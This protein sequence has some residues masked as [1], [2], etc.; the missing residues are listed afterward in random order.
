MNDPHS[1]SDGPFSKGVG[2][3]YKNIEPNADV[4]VALSIFDRK[5]KRQ[6]KD[7]LDDISKV[8]RIDSAMEDPIDAISLE[9]INAGIESVIPGDLL[10][11]VNTIFKENPII[12][13]VRAYGGYMHDQLSKDSTVPPSWGPNQRAN[14]KNAMEQWREAVRTTLTHTDIDGNQVK[15]QAL[16]TLSEK[17]LFKQAY[18]EWI[19]AKVE[20]KGLRRA[21]DDTGMLW[22]SE[23]WD[24]VSDA[25]DNIFRARELLK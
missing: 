20:G 21:L 7:G 2:G 25:M 3:E 13:M 23:N 9:E 17:E 1:P 14:L 4:P 16:Q 5:L 24:P 22:N 18:S 15:H 19:D 11:G 10:L 12:G 6:L 8:H